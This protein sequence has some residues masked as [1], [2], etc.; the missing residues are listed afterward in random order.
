M[1]KGIT[2]ECKENQLEK[3]R[4]GKEP[5]KGKETVEGKM[6]GA[7]KKSKMERGKKKSKTKRHSKAMKYQ[8]KE[9]TECGIVAKQRTQRNSTRKKTAI[10]NC[11]KKK[12]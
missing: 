8:G 4:N 7:V 3:G 12:K 5:T 11:S 1:K 9:K 2:K 10:Q 6:K